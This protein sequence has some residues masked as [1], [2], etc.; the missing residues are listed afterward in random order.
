MVLLCSDGLTTMVD[1][2]TIGQLLH[3]HSDAEAAAGELVRAALAAGGE[4]N[5]TVVIFRIDELPDADDDE[6]TTG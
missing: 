3:E 5:V 6:Q 1:E 4:D 2:Q